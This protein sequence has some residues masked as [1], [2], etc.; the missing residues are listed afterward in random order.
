[1]KT[2]I[3]CKFEGGGKNPLDVGTDIGSFVFK[4]SYL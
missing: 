3:D 4:K 1:M 2:I